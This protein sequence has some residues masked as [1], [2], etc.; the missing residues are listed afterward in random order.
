MILDQQHWQKS[1]R[2]YIVI[3]TLNSNII[4]VVLFRQ[5]AERS[6]RGSDFSYGEYKEEFRI[7][8]QNDEEQTKVFDKEM[9]GFII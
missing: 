5:G 4:F 1:E 3:C 9:M 6:T 8:N 7:T 2:D